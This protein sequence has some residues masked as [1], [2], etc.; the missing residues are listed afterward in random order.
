MTFHLS[1][2]DRALL[3]TL[4]PPEDP[5]SAALQAVSGLEAEEARYFRIMANAK[6]VIAQKEAVERQAAEDKA[7]EDGKGSAEQRA[8]RVAELMASLKVRTAHAA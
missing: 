4:I 3:L 6:W 5:L 8:A 7:I 1:H 2:D